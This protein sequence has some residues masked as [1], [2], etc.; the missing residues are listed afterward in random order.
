MA[1]TTDFRETVQARAK[2]DPRLR[3]GLLGEAIE[4]LLS[5]EVGLGEGVVA[6]LHQCHGGVS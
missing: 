6:R 4:G 2:R 3:E 1:L 5:G